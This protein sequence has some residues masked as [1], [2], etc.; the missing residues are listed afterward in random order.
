MTFESGN[1]EDLKDKSEKMWKASF[2]Y[3]AIAENAVKRFSSE[4]YY[5]KLLRYYKGED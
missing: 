5:E 2:D 4:A 3:K 1:I